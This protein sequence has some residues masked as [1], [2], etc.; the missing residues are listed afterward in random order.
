MGP[1]VTDMF[2]FLKGELIYKA[3]AYAV[4]VKPVI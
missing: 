1:L 2:F 4:D 3:N